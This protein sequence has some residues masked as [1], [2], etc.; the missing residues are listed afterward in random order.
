MCRFLT[1]AALFLIIT[2][3][4]A[5][6]GL[7]DDRDLVAAKCATCH[8]LDYYITPRSRKAWELTVY[9]MRDFIWDEAQKYTDEE[10][11]RIIDFLGEHFDEYST[12][13]ATV[14]FADAQS[15]YDVYYTPLPAA[16]PDLPPPTIVTA[17]V[18]AVEQ[19]EPTAATAA[20]AAVTAPAPPEMPE[21]IRQRIENPRWK[22]SAAMLLYARHSGYAAVVFLLALLVSGH[23]RRRLKKAFRPL[24]IAA[25]LGLFLSLAS[26]GAIYLLRYGNPP[27]AWYWFGLAS[28]VAVVVVELVGIMRKKMGK[29]FLRA[30]MAGGYVGLILAVLHWIWAWL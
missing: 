2:S 4:T 19:P 11:E 3:V 17:A 24:H 6:D 15:A 20:V 13:D 22:P 21:E 9:N 5:V 8:G 12:N 18:A 7:S 30:H 28:F 16:E 14:V 27:V 10:A 25:A 23:S 1:Q 29:R 26:H